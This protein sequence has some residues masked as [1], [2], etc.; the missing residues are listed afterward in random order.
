MLQTSIASL[1][2]SVIPSQAIEMLGVVGT[3]GAFEW[4]IDDKLHDHV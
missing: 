4:T 2:F 3:S 1:R